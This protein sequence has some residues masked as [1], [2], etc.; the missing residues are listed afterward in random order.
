MRRTLFGASIAAVALACSAYSAQDDAVSPPG[1]GG[2]DGGA[3][4]ANSDAA[5]L[6]AGA[7]AN[8]DG[9]VPAKQCSA[10]APFGAPSPLSYSDVT[11]VRPVPGG[12]T[13]LFATDAGSPSFEDVL[14]SSYPTNP[15][16]A[17]V[18]VVSSAAP[19]RSPAP[20]SP[21]LLFYEAEPN[22]SIPRIFSATRLQT[23]QTFTNAI[24]EALTTPGVSGRDP[25]ALSADVLYFAMTPGTSGG[26]DVIRA[27]RS[28]GVWTKSAV[29]AS[30]LDERYPVVT[31]DELVIFFARSDSGVSKIYSASRTSAQA[32]FTS[33]LA[34]DALNAGVKNQYPTWISPDACTLL[35]ISDRDGSYRAYEAKRTAQ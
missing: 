32:P 15:F 23:G 26:A 28:G 35:F 29:L 24:D 27:Q 16:E 11:S 25:F 20:V 7:D 18:K 12:T 2:T 17:P 8:V 21:L 33:V 13:A 30:P 14:E 31:P 3:T 5:A 34:V 1:D 4:D 19:E 6:D 10:D 9:S 22:G